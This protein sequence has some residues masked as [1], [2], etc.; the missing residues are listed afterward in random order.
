L[1]LPLTWLPLPS[2]CSLWLTK[3]RNS[4]P[5]QRRM[6]HSETFMSQPFPG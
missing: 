2:A 3:A 6:S 5:E 4:P 1:T